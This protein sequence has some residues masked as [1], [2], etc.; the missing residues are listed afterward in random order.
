M[1]LIEFDVLFKALGPVRQKIRSRK[2]YSTKKLFFAKILIFAYL[3]QFFDK[4][5]IVGKYLQL[6]VEV[7]VEVRVTDEVLHFL[8]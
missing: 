6:E 4:K 1:D 5:F 8:T 3:V 7:E 2:S